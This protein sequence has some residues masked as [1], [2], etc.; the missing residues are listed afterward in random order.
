MS[1]PIAEIKLQEQQAKEKV[2]QKKIEIDQ[3]LS[4][5]NQKHQIIFEMLPEDIKNEVDKFMEAAKKEIAAAKIKQRQKLNK[6]LAEINSVNTEK[7]SRAAN[8]IVEK[9]TSF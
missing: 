3:E 4:E 1:N 5:L 9:I 6:Q 2:E 7:L 8:I